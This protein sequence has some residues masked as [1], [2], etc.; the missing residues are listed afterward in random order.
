MSV[1]T[2]GTLGLVASIVLIILLYVKVLPRKMDGKI[3]NKFLNWLHN[4][5]YFK[6]FYIEDILRFVFIVTSV[7]SFCIGFFM[8][9]SVTEWWTGTRSN[10]AMGLA[11]MVGG[12][13]LMRL[14]FEVQMM[15]IT[16][17]RNI[18]E[19]NSKMDRLAA[20]EKKAEKPMGSV[21][22]EEAGK[23][24]GSVKPEEAGKPMGSV[25]PEE[26]GKTSEPMMVRHSVESGAKR[27]CRNCGKVVGSKA[28]FCPGCGEKIEP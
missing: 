22:P 21:K 14:L 7:L 6:R 4:Y 9:F 16:A 8:L 12:P 23:P 27:V 28:K 11:I 3:E 15:A 25:K 10:F 26:A 20:G 24:M 17:I 5:F 13:I 1:N 19:I 18:I 2:A